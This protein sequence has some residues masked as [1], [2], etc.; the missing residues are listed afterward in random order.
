M[1]L[2]RMHMVYMHTHAEG[3]DGREQ[4]DT[5]ATDAEGNKNAEQTLQDSQGQQEDDEDEANDYERMRLKRI[6]ENK[7]IMMMSGILDAKDVCMQSLTNGEEFRMS[8]CVSMYTKNVCMHVLRR[9][10]DYRCISVR[11]LQYFH[12]VGSIFVCL[13][14]C[15]CVCLF[16]LNVHDYVCIIL[17]TLK[18]TFWKGTKSA[19]S[20]QMLLVAEIAYM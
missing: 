7:R 13:S 3:K 14:V 15:L 10:V 19:C 8:A 6:E 5:K 18:S 16:V 2:L 1:F 12:N 4:D 9:C 17:L 11:Q 20:F